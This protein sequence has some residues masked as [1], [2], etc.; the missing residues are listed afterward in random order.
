MELLTE[1]KTQISSAQLRAAQSVNQEL[2]LLYWRMGKQ[3]SERMLPRDERLF[4]T[5]S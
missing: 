5:Q 4:A 2:V 3:I 1:L